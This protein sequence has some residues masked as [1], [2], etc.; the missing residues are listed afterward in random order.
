LQD[1]YYKNIQKQGFNFSSKFICGYKEGTLIIEDNPAYIPNFFGNNINVTAIVGKNGSGKSNIL[2]SLIHLSLENTYNKQKKLIFSIYFC[3]S[4]YYLYSTHD[5]T[6]KINSNIPLLK[7]N[8][9]FLMYYDYSLS[10]ILFDYDEI[11]KDIVDNSY[12]SEI[13]SEQS[14][15]LIM[16]PIKATNHISII[17][18]IDKKSMDY[19]LEFNINNSIKFIHIDDFFQPIYFKVSFDYRRISGDDVF[20]DNDNP[21]LKKLN[22]FYRPDNFLSEFNRDEL[23]DLTILYILQITFNKSREMSELD[24]FKMSKDFEKLWYQEDDSQT[25]FDK[26]NINSLIT[27][28]KNHDYKD[29]FLN[30]EL[31]IEKNFKFINFLKKQDEAFSVDNRLYRIQENKNLLKNLATWISIELL[32][33]YEISFYDLSYGEKFLIKF[34]Y[35]LLF[36]IDTLNQ[37]HKYKNITLLLDEV[38]QGLH[39]EWQKKF[40]YLLINILKTKT[41]FNFNIICTTHSPFILSDLPKEN[42]IFLKDGRQDKGI[43]DKQTFGA[44]IHTLLSDSFFMEDGLMGE[45][46]KNRIEEVVNYLQEKES[47]ITNH[48]EA[49]QIIEIIGEPILKMKLR[50]M[51]ENYK[52]KNNLESEEDIKKQIEELQKKLEEKQNNG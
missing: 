30:E 50:K 10:A 48:E 18:N 46:A 32:D 1:V 3:N 6:L 14:Y 36:Q 2:E 25:S 40:L 29:L 39:P 27:Y 12:F 33:I 37:L 43:K 22:D 24:S 21:I 20:Y 52:K 5:K 26:Y 38:E 34:V 17:E 8:E 44:N 31:E 19:M 49:L 9:V 4:K 23:I 51:L 13:R 35:N 15:P 11:D 45:F 41:N 47:E 28:I 42:I 7:N 16:Q